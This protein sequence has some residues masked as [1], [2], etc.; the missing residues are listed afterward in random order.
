MMKTFIL[1]VAVF[2]MNAF[3]DPEVVVPPAENTGGNNAQ[4]VE[5]NF[6]K[7][8]AVLESAYDAMTSVKDDQ[9]LA[10][11]GVRLENLAKEMLAIEAKVE[12]DQK[13]DEKLMRAFA[14]RFLEMNEKVE[15]QMN[16]VR[17]LNLPIE[18]TNARDAQF[19]IFLDAIE[20]MKKK[21]RTL[22]PPE[23]LSLFVEQIKADEA[24][25]RLGEMPI[26]PK[27]EPQP[28]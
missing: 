15:K 7:M 8:A 19:R 21:T 24:R 23:R 20:P 6:S 16:I 10:K 5:A 9:S 14:I 18:I 1:M 4:S 25:K 27:N 26:L 28:N 12:M 3:A 11:S 2:G 22:F 17:A 13:P